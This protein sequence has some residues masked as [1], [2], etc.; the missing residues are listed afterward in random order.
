MIPFNRTILNM[1][2]TT[3]SVTRKDG[4]YIALNKTIRV[5]PCVSVRMSRVIGNKRVTIQRR[6]S[7][8]TFGGRYVAEANR[9]GNW[10]AELN[11]RRFIQTHRTKLGRPRK[12]HYFAT[13]I[14]S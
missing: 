6:F 4:V 8:S 13:D 9:F 14:V 12:S 10:A 2:N 5:Y 3:V 1:N 11:D 7:E